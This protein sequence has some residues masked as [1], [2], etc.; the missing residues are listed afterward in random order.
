MEKNFFF[1]ITCNKFFYDPHIIFNVLKQNLDFIMLG[2]RMD[3][4]LYTIIIIKGTV[5]GLLV[6]GRID[7]SKGGWLDIASRP[8][9]WLTDRQTK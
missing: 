8:D 5:F 2:Q 4:W 9:V 3:N 6:S 7:G 1:Q